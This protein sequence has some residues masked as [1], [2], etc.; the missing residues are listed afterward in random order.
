VSRP[1]EQHELVYVFSAYVPVAGVIA[2]LRTHA[3]VEQDV[4]VQTTINHGGT[5]IVPKSIDID[6]LSLTPTKTEL[7]P[8]IIRKFELLRFG[9]VAQWET[10]RRAVTTYHLLCHDDKS[11]PRQF[12]FLSR[13]FFN[14]R[15][16][17]YVDVHQRLHQPLVWRDAD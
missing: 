7:L 14:S 1:E 11:L 10:F 6:G 12:L 9:Y 8:A 2:N 16:W 17:P 3:K 13:S 5:H 15:H 4:I